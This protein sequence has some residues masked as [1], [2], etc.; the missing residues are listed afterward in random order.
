MGPLAWIAEDV[1]RC[2]DAAL[3][4]LASGQ[5]SVA[6]AALHQ[7]AG[8]LE[9]AGNGGVARVVTAIEALARRDGTAAAAAMR[10]DISDGASYLLANAEFC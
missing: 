5:A 6:A 3:K 4:A 10:R 2:L 8:A 9:L 7:A 1:G